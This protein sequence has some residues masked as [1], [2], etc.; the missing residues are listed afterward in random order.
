MSR[1]SDKFAKLRGKRAGRGVKDILGNDVPVDSTA[2]GALQFNGEAA[3]AAL[4]P[5]LRKHLELPASGSVTL[6]ADQFDHLVF[7]AVGSGWHSA[8]RQFGRWVTE[9][10]GS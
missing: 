4:A 2:V 7:D 10:T 3:V 1:F 6:T 8:V 5:A 9:A